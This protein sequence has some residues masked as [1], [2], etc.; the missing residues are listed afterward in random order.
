MSDGNG[1]N[2]NNKP[3]IGSG[4]HKQKS[5]AG[6]SEERRI[7]KELIRLA[8]LREQDSATQERPVQDYLEYG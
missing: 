2:N 1:N 3:K 5:Q 8:T 7:I 6:N 4:T